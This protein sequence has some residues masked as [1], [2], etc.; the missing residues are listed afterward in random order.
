MDADYSDQNPALGELYAAHLDQIKSRHDRALEQAGASHA[1]I[2]S[3]QPKRMFLDDNDYPFKANPHFVSWAPLTRLPY[4]Y[5]VY[6]PGQVPILARRARR[7]G[8]LL[9]TAFRCSHRPCH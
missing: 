9:D 3:G 8:R 6:T 1:V 4:S 5:I 7:A 2:Y